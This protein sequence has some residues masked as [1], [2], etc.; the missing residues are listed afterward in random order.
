M[1]W[2][3][4]GSIGEKIIN[5]LAR[6]LER[7]FGL[8]VLG[9]HRVSRIEVEQEAIG[10][11]KVKGQKSAPLGKVRAVECIDKNGQKVELRDVDACVLAVGAKGIRAI[12]GGSPELSLCCPDLA[13]AASLNTI[14][15][16]AVRIWLDRIVPTRSPVNV[17]SRFEGLRGAGGTFFLLDQL[18]GN[19]AELW[20]GDTP[21]G[22]VL[23][24]DFYNA[25]GLLSLADEDIVRLLMSDLLPSAVPAFRWGY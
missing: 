11:D 12:L 16:I 22:S 25:G 14:D 2:I 19:T 20:G 9:G 8:K 6:E 7:D 21:Q 24:C 17:L 13:L 4:S 18:Q 15:C 10:P 23:S 5:P 3:K 1:R